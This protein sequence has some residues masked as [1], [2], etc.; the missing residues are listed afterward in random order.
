L[1]TRRGGE[2]EH[3]GTVRP[4][5]SCGCRLEAAWR[6]VVRDE[7]G[8]ALV[9]AI[10]FTLVLLSMLS[11]ALVLAAAGAHDAEGTKAGQKANAL[12]GSGTGNALSPTQFGGN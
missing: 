10:L 9:L 1:V 12:A 4:E 2:L 8:V 11:S 5:N 7:Q 3:Y 6:R